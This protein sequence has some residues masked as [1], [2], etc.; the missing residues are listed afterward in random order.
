MR[1]C[2][3][4]RMKN[5][6]SFDKFDWLITIAVVAM[7]TPTFYRL[8]TLGWKTADYTHAYFILPI[9]LRLI[10]KKRD[11]LIKSDE[12][13][14]S[15]I[16]LFVL[17]IV[18]YLFAALNAF[19]FLEGFAFVVMMWAV[20]RLRLKKESFK[21]VLF[22][23]AYLLFLVP[24]PSLAIDMATLPLKKI[25]T[26]G[27]YFLLNLFQLPVEVYGAVLKVGEHELFITDACSGFRSIVTLLALGAV[28]AYFQD[29]SLKKKWIIFL[30]VFP[31]GI[32][33]NIG[34]IGLTG[35]ISYFVGMEYAEGFFHT[36]SGMFLF[37]FT[38]LGLV[39][40]T[41]FICKKHLKVRKKP[42]NEWLFDD[43]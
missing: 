13:S 3:K 40:L 25:S 9:S 22:P 41:E 35:C 33:G 28:Y 21:K 8:V 42:D 29:T 34:R 36:F 23:L 15:G 5:L 27:S 24:P 30:S 20:F 39:V 17:G 14:K 7:F 1:K 18:F 11:V 4:K 32:L 16:I 31:I 2:V 6:K 12:I 38:V 43:E 19:M 26:Y 37:V 10:F